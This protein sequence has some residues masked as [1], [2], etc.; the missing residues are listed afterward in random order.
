MTF[1]LSTSL[2]FDHIDRPEEFGTL[3][4]LQEIARTVEAAGFYAGTV[5][6]HPAP[7]ARW[8][9]AGGHYAQD[10]FVLLSMLG[11]STTKLRLQTNILV[12]PYRNPFLTA[13]AVSSLDHFTNGRVILGLGAGYMKAEY[14]ALGVDF[15]ARNDLMDEYINAM[16]LAWTGE[17]FTFEGTGYTALGNRMLP[18]PAQTPHP[19]LLVGGNSKRALRRAVEL[20]DAWHPFFVPKSVTD[21]ARTANLEGDDDI[22]AAIGYM[23]DHCGKVGRAEPPKV[24]ASSTYAVK[25]GWSAQEALDHYANLKS[26]GVHGSGATIHAETRAQYCDIAL[27]FGEEVIAKIDF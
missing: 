17:D 1:T 20:G 11:A 3:D 12:L 10:P 25:D 5:T 15:D 24:I 26:L 27:K 4:A 13:R 8:L 7:S 19:P 22:L 23:A 14:K 21:T 16:K 2:P 18:T 9:D 6:D